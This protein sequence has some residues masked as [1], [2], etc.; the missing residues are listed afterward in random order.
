MRSIFKGK[1]SHFQVSLTRHFKFQ[2]FQGVRGPAQTLYS[3]GTELLNGCG[4]HFTYVIKN[5]TNNKGKNAIFIILPMTRYTLISLQHSPKGIAVHCDVLIAIH[6]ID[7][8]LWCFE[9]IKVFLEIANYPWNFDMMLRSMGGGQL[10]INT[11][12]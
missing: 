2:H 3:N 1:T 6:F 5:I 4:T 10:Q 11:L 8:R 12:L 7:P 9:V